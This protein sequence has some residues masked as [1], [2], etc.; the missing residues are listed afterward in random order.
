MI[1]DHPYQ[2]AGYYSLAIL[3][4]GTLLGYSLAQTR[5]RCLKAKIE[6]YK[7]LCGEGGRR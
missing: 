7:A 3:L 5:I 4:I 2:F 1:T 6:L